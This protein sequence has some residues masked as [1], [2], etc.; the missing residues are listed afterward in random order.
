MRYG[1]HGRASTLAKKTDYHHG[2][3]R[4]TLIEHSLQLIREKGIG[5]FSLLQAA[6]AA[7]VSSGAP[8]RHFASKAELLDEIARTGFTRLSNALNQP[9]TSEGAEHLLDLGLRYIAF[10]RANPAMFTV[11]FD[12]TD[13]QA[14]SPEG[15]AALA[16][17]ADSLRH[18]QS[19][20]GL[21]QPLEDA[22]RATWAL[23]H[24]IAH[25]QL[26]DMLSFQKLEVDALRKLMRPVLLGGIVAGG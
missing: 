12:A 4:D 5:G 18:L 20:R 24:G 25:L 6:N 17:V 21:N 2:A 13:R 8:Y 22:V 9:V 11:M 14:Q 23:V 15:K 10:A 7:G 19:T 16:P 26:G 1:R 3:L